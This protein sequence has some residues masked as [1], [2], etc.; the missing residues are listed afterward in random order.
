MKTIEYRYVIGERTFVSS[1]VAFVRVPY[2]DPIH[3]KYRAG[4][5]VRVHYQ[6]D[7]PELSVIEPGAPVLGIAAASTA[8]VA[9]LGVGVCG[10][11][12]N[13]RRRR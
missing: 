3:R 9:M 11:Y 1:K 12:F 10:L 4:M 6:K 13:F 8:S 7:Q 2:V 5:A